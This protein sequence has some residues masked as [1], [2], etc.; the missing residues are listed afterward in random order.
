MAVSDDG[1]YS[2]HKIGQIISSRLASGPYCASGQPGGLWVDGWMIEADGDGRRTGAGDAYVYI[3]FVDH[4]AVDHLNRG[5]SI[6]RVGKAALLAAV[7][8]G[9]SPTFLKYYNPT[10]APGPA[11]AFFTE[12]GLG[13]R[14][15]PVVA[16]DVFIGSPT[17]AYDADRRCFVLAYQEQQ[18]RILLRSGETLF[19]WSPAQP[20]FAIDPQDEL[21]LF[22]PSLVGLRDDPTVLDRQFYLYFLERR[23]HNLEPRMVRITVT[24][25]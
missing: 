14:S 23:P 21:R 25:Q 18:K 22:Y 8:A 2:F 5:I 10:G 6:A 24:G 4:E 9:K 13:G 15:T 3:L 17:L 20:V 16:S 19:A 12:P 1:G 7:A 11:G